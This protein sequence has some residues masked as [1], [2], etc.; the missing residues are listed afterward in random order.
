MIYIAYDGLMLIRIRFIND[1]GPG[2]VPTFRTFTCR[3]R[4]KRSFM[5]MYSRCITRLTI[6]FL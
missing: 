1:H 4:S 5:Q 6:T 2:P 3:A